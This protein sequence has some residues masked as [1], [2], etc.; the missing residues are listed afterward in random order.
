MTAEKFWMGWLKITIII[1]IIAG[2][3]LIIL[4]NTAYA[5]I[6][7]KQINRVFYSGR[8]PEQ[9]VLLMKGWLLGVSGAVMAG[10]GSSMLYI[11]YHPFKKREKWAW[12]SIFYPL[13]LWYLL[14]SIVSLYYGAVFN[15]TIN[16]ILFL[17]IIA[18]LLF[19]RN[20]FFPKLNPLS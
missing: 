15:V 4:G 13:L 19:L 16:T 5:E 10:W 8:I 3:L 9:S 12:R 14:D 1:I 7:N 6:L 2:I 20:L 11:V 17:Q 18:P